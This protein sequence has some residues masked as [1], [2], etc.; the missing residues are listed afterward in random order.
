MRPRILL[1]LSLFSSS[2]SSPLERRI[3]FVASTNGGSESF[4][5]LADLLISHS[6]S[7]TVAHAYCS[8]P[9]EVTNDTILPSPPFCYKNWTVP[10]MQ[11]APHIQHVP[12]IQMLGNS[13][14]LNFEHPYI[15]ASKYIEWAQTWGFHGYLLDAEFK[16]DDAP[17]AAFLNVFADALHNVNKSLGVFLYP[18]LGKKDLVNSTRADYWLGTWGGRCSSISSFIWG[19]NPYWGRGGMMLYQTDAKCDNAGIETMFS[20]WNESRMEE[21]SFWANG[22]DMGQDWYTAMTKFLNQTNNSISE[23]SASLSTSSSST[24]STTTS[25]TTPLEQ[26]SLPQTQRF[27]QL[28]STSWDRVPLFA[29]VRWANFSSSDL[30]GLSTFR[31][32]TVQVEPD[33]PLKCE[34]QANDIQNKLA[35]IGAKTSTLMYG[36]LYFAEPNCHYFGKVERSPW[37]WLND[38][39]GAPVRPAGRYAFDLRDSRAPSWWVENVLLASNVTGGGFGDS[40]CGSKPSW[41]NSSAQDA[42]AAAQLRTHAL[43]TTEISVQ[44]EGLYIANCPIVP[45]IGDQPI[46]GVNGEMIESWCSDFSPNGKSPATFCRD[47]LVEAVVLASSKNKTWLQARYYLNSENGYNP[48]FGLA[49]FL[50]AANEGSFFGASRDWDYY[51]DWEKLLSWPWVN[52]TLGSPLSLFANMTDKEGCGWTRD[53]ANATVSVNLCTKHLFA[54]IEWL[55][56]SEDDKEEGEVQEGLIVEKVETVSSIPPFRNVQIQEGVCSYNQEQ[57]GA[58]VVYA[59]W[60]SDGFACLQ[61]REERRGKRR[62]E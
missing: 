44:T 35:S 7:W 8:S 26:V 61:W 19:C 54:R 49:A 33:S 24:M 39:S 21:T 23:S 31:S 1:F 36:N 47:E 28:P 11:R 27:S 10:I 46:L 3:G 13:G 56:V 9:G 22:A 40:G 20:T 37:I 53:Y 55:G 60:S 6:E 51:N 58:V 15:F 62:R 29:H 43:A 18:D 45:Q 41:L 14:P 59:P 32:V 57:G 52:Y 48:Q 2:Y 17:F 42:Y 38:S 5:P 30:S 12:I 25:M 16:G 50:I 4:Q 34:D